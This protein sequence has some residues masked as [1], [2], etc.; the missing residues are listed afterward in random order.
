MSRSAY[1]PS[2]LVLPLHGA[3]NPNT[4]NSLRLQQ[5]QPAAK[6]NFTDAHQF[7]LLQEA[8]SSFLVSDRCDRADWVSQ[9]SHQ[10]GLGVEGWEA[11]TRQKH[12]G[13]VATP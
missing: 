7:D 1:P 8:P 12:D 4:H 3:L 11:S 10:A 13:S 5:L 2:A 6:T 9:A